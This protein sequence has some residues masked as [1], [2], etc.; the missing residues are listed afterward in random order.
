MRL[1]RRELAA[2]AIV[3]AALAA[4]QQPAP[5]MDELQAAKDRLKNTV[6]ALGAVTLPMSTEP[7]AVF[8]V[9]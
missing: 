3:P 9:L 5:A 4:P 8:K 1:T 7:A 6:N 2:A